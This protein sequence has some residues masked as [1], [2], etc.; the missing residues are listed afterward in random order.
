[1]PK[2]VLLIASLLALYIAITRIKQ[3]PVANRRSAYIQLAF[4]VAAGVAILLAATGKMHWI[5][6]LLTGLLVLVRQ[7]LPLL[8]QLAPHLWGR[9]NRSTAGQSQVDTSLLRMTLDH[10]SG[11]L[12]GEVLAGTFQGR[13]LS[14]LDQAQLDQLLDYCQA[15]DADSAQLL[16][17][18]L[19]QRFGAAYQSQDSY[20]PSSSGTELTEQEALAT[21][22]LNSGATK[23][24]VISA[25]RKLMQKLH[26]DRGGNDYLAARVNAAKDFLLGE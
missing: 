7:T 18:Y 22:G 8:I 2:L 13:T 14:Q 10:D 3:M 15:N 12:D 25:H 1:M 5:G 23:E 11:K 4:I 9:L 26:P 17:T 21:L 16:R 24:E 20:Q 19:E 6:A